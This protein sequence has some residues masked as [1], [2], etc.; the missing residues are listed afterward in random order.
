M[1]EGMRPGITDREG[2]VSVL[3]DKKGTETITDDQVSQDGTQVSQDGGEETL[4]VLAETQRS[5]RPHLSGA[6]QP[7]LPVLQQQKPEPPITPW[8]ACSSTRYVAGV[9]LPCGLRVW[10]G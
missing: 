7:L 4:L 3:E 5:S 6:Q 2:C 1:T 10:L 8:R 9:H